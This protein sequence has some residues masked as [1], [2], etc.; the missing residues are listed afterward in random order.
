MVIADAGDA[1]AGILAGGGADRVCGG[2]DGAKIIASGIAAGLALT[3]VTAIGR[4]GI[5][6]G[7]FSVGAA[8]LFA[9]FGAA[10]G[11]GVAVTV[12]VTVAVTVT[13]GRGAVGALLAVLF[14]I[15]FIVEVWVWAGAGLQEAKKRKG[16]EKGDE[17]IRIHKIGLREE[18]RREEKRREEK[19]RE[20][21]RKEKK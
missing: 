5:G 20:E 16:S 6:A 4:A 8:G 17:S 7:T 18:K 15:V 3:V 19:R 10:F 11:V 14:G 9:G 12:T 1:A 13:G 21:K 2:L